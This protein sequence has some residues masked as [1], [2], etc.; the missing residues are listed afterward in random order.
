MASPLTYNPGIDSIVLAR[1]VGALYYAVDGRSTYPDTDYFVRRPFQSLTFVK[2]YFNNQEFRRGMFSIYVNETGVIDTNTGYL[3]GGVTKEYWWKEEDLSD[4][5]L[6]EKSTDLTDYAT[7]VYV[8][9]QIAPLLVQI[10]AI[11]EQLQELTDDLVQEISD[12][13]E[14]D[15][16]N[17]LAIFNEA[18]R[19]TLAEQV[20][21]DAIIN[22]TNRA[23]A[24]EATKADA[25]A[26]ITDTV[27]SFGDPSLVGN[28]YT[29]LSLADK[30]VQLSWEDENGAHL[31]FIVFNGS[32]V[33]TLPI[34][35]ASGFS[36]LIRGQT[37]LV[38][39]YPALEGVTYNNYQKYRL[40]QTNL[41]ANYT[42]L[43]YPGAVEY[44][45][46]VNTLAHTANGIQYVVGTNSSNFSYLDTLLTTG[47][48][49]IEVWEVEF[50][51]GAL[52]S[53][54]SYGISF[55]ATPY[56]SRAIT[57]TSSGQIIQY[58][59]NY[60]SSK[61]VRAANP[62]FAFLANDIIKIGVIRD[63]INSLYICYTVKNG[64]QSPYYDFVD[65]SS[66]KVYIA[67]RGRANGV[68]SL[69]KYQSAYDVDSLDTQINSVRDY[70]SLSGISY[71]N[72]IDID[73]ADI[74]WQS[75]DDL[76][77]SLTYSQ[78]AEGLGILLGTSGSR[79]VLFSNMSLD[80][81]GDPAD[82]DITGDKVGGKVV[83]RITVISST[84]IM[85]IGFGHYK[86]VDVNEAL[87]IGYRNDGAIFSWDEANVFTQLLAADVDNAFIVGDIIT[88]E[89]F[90][91]RSAGLV[92]V[93]IYK[94]DVKIGSTF[95]LTLSNTDKFYIYRRG[96]ISSIVN[97]AI[98]KSNALTKNLGGGGSGSFATYY[99]STSG[100]DDNSGTSASPF[101]TLAKAKEVLGTG[102]GE[103]VVAGGTYRE[104]MP[105]NFINGQSIVYRSEPFDK[106]R[107]LGSVALSFVKTGGYTNIYEATHSTV[108]PE[109]GNLS[110]VSRIF[111]DGNPSKSIPSSER[112]PQ[113]KGLN[114]R[115]PFTELFNVPFNTNLATTLTALDAISTGGFYHD[116]VNSKIYVKSSN[117][118]DPT[119][120]GFSY[121]VP[122][123]A[124]TT[125]PSSIT[126]ASLR[127]LGIEFYFS[128][129]KGASYKYISDIYRYKCGCFGGADDGFVD[130]ACSGYTYG[131]EGASNGND[132]VNGHMT[133]ITGYATLDQRQGSD[134]MHY[135]SQWCHDNYGDGNSHHELGQ[136]ITS[137]GLYEYN[138]KSGVAPSNTCQWVDYNS[139]MR[140]NKGVA[141]RGEGVE[142]INASADLRN[143]CS[144]IGFNTVCYGNRIGVG[145]YTN[146][147][148]KIV[149][150][151]VVSKNNDVAD[152]NA[153]YGTIEANNCKGTIKLETN[154][155]TV[156]PVNDP[157]LT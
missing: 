6:V 72:F 128:N 54:P 22:E 119:T 88:H 134:P 150:Y 115:L 24:A 3:I 85:G 43:T 44:V 81:N 141:G 31:P 142:V 97:V 145:V 55:G 16:T 106:V 139:I 30:T 87:A 35:P 33:A 144:F 124:C 41:P 96:A 122:A 59:P 7:L 18:V 62:D 67:M 133:A 10:D 147:N 138:K 93:D 68:I 77:S 56:G 20:N 19:A 137:N 135:E 120:N 80:S 98:Y 37:G 73:T 100:S 51:L 39:S 123:R 110:G 109:I 99:V 83:S 75:N 79:S 69:N 5:G 42:G 86:G 118:S 156:T 90:L 111:E 50:V 63:T 94:N 29:N 104:P 155:G 154:G 157:Q 11:D 34:T 129:T 121:E 89:W 149:L 1:A 53:S 130:D 107:I 57:Y 12:R 14:G 48:K 27:I 140:Y 13:Q 32:G 9:E 136:V 82:I 21:A 151:N 25:S 125:I 60:A 146:S 58:E 70:A 84:P 101:L 112:L 46:S 91:D 61:T 40:T 71:Y 116:A 127:T 64:V 65:F 113:Q 45:P 132:G 148:N 47:D 28:Q 36:G 153:D 26:I 95:T 103:V 131:D 152:Y 52:V 76:I 8:D 105:F 143:G 92:T 17:A 49:K 108:I 4:D 102:N 74:I 117:A 78:Q 114:F 23:I 126:I 38:F 2:S 66:S 15:A